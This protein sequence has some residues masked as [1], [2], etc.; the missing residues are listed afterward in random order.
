[1]SAS[2]KRLPYTG[3]LS[4]LSTNGSAPWWSSC[5]WVMTKA[6]HVVAAFE[7]PGDVG[8]HEVDAEHL[9]A[10]ELDAAVDDHDLPAVLDGGHVLA[11]LTETAE[12]DDPGGFA[13]HVD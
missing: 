3:L 2:V 5:P 13:T 12:R 7:Q 8:Q 9:V 4:C 10:R 1:M 6:E 11:D